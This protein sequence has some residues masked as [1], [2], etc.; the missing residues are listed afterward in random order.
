MICLINKF[1][2]FK[3]SLTPKEGERYIFLTLYTNR[4]TNVAIE[5]TNY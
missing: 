4:I 5:I 3:S 1:S 2:I